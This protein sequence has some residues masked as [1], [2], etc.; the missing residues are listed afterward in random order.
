MSRRDPRGFDLDGGG[1]DDE[2]PT[3]RVSTPSAPAQ[4]DPAVDE[5]RAAQVA[6]QRALQEAMAEH[7]RIEGREPLPRPIGPPPPPAGHAQLPSLEETREV[8]ARILG[9][10]ADRAPPSPTPIPDVPSTGGPSAPPAPPRPPT[11]TSVGAAPRPPDP[12]ATVRA[13]S[14][15]V[16]GPPSVAFDPV[17][18]AAA[19]GVL[20]SPDA[21]PATERRE[22]VPVLCGDG[23]EVILPLAAVLCDARQNYFRGGTPW[24]LDD[25]KV[26]DTADGIESLGLLNPIGVRRLDPP[27]ERDEPAVV[28]IPSATSAP[29]ERGAETDAEAGGS[30]RG[31]SAADRRGERVLVTHYTH[32]VIDGYKRFAALQLLGRATGRF[33]VRD[34]D[35]Q[36]AMLINGLENTDRTEFDEFHAAHYFA[37]LVRLTGADP[38]RVASLVKASPARVEQ[39]VLMVQR[40]PPE[41]M[42]KFRCRQIPEV[43]RELAKIARI[44]RETPEETRQAMIDEWV[45]AEERIRIAEGQKQE[46][47]K[48]EPVAAEPADARRRSMSR[49]QVESLR[50]SAR[51]ASEWYDPM[52]EQWRPI[53]EDQRVFADAMLRLV[54]DLVVDPKGRG[55]LR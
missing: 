26:R 5:I 25:R 28:W 44:Q 24:T 33:T 29:S 42:E 3:P 12:T 38:E 8:M 7:A 50:R 2:P 27:V 16:Q 53:E 32:Q 15:T 23:R 48:P 35:E 20:P 17:Q 31:A 21:S 11:A 22:P 43:R 52:T 14:S 46:K 55:M 6:M 37:L 10:G 47:K 13:P 54:S 9:G 34:A 4:A 41:L 45:R 18:H 36:I 39:L 19:V 51:Q 49:R 40:L 1:L 30:D